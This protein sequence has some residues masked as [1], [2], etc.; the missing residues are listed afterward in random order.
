MKLINCKC[1]SVIQRGTYSKHLN[2]SKHINFVKQLKFEGWVI[3]NGFKQAE[4]EDKF[5]T[6]SKVNTKKRG[7]SIIKN[8]CNCLE[9]QEKA[10]DYMVKKQLAEQ[11]KNL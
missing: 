7:G 11:N 6:P 8:P 1:G 4:Y 5:F 3:S 10:V 9:C 2:S